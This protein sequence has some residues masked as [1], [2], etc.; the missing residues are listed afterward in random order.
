MNKTENGKRTIS[1]SRLVTLTWVRIFR[2]SFSST[3]NSFSL[4]SAETTK[5]FC[6][7]RVRDWDAW[8]VAWLCEEHVPI[9]SNSRVCSSMEWTRWMSY[10]VTSVTDMPFLP[11]EEE[12]PSRR[13][14]C[15]VYQPL[16]MILLFFKKKKK[17]VHPLLPF[18]RLCGCRSWGVQGC[19]GWLPPGPLEYPNLWSSTR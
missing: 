15:L 12:R 5:S 7:T 13:E 6:H 19:C 16:M 14:L 10:C 4:V 3:G 17:V 8:L 2:T 11:A 9:G 1:H 18:V